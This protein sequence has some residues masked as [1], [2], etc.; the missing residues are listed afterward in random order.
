MNLRIATLVHALVVLFGVACI[1]AASASAAATEQPDRTRLSEKVSGRVARGVI[2]ESLSALDAPENRARLGRILNS[3]QM[4]DALHDLTESIVKG[5]FDGMADGMGKSGI[6]DIDVAAS[7]GKGMNEHVTP[8]AARLTYRLVDSALTA[9]LS[10]KHIAQFEKLAQGVTH[11]AVAGIGSGLEHEIGPA[12][13][14]TL[15]KDLGPAIGMV[16]ERDILPS[17]GRGLDS[18]EMKSA[19]S[20]LVHS[21]A[22]ELVSGTD[23]ALDVAAEKNREDGQESNLQIFGGRVAMGYAISLFVAFAFGTMLIVMTV[24]LVRSN[25]R[26]RRQQEATAKREA[27]MLA[28]LEEMEGSESDTQTAAQRLLRDHIREQAS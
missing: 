1:P 7:I 27:A 9:S 3:P 25:R 19:I 13:A 4:R 26:Q 23:Q 5:V 8:A 18:P 12:L 16:I 21:V 10:D 11:A 14:A 17:V 28:L 2:D 6:G 15:E 20:N 24:V 22:T